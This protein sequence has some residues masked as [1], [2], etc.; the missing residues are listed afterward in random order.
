M[1]EVLVE[2][3]EPVR[4]TDGLRYIARAC[5]NET[6]TGLWQGWIE[7]VPTTGGGV[8]RSSRETT[9][10]NRQDAMYWATGLTNVYLEGALDRARKPIERAPAEPASTPAYSGPAPEVAPPPAAAEAVLNPFSVFR[11]GE[12]ALRSQL[13]A[14]AQWHLVNIVRAFELSDLSAASLGRMTAAELAELIVA[15]VRARPETPALR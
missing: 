2:F 4:D 12:A 15:E 11:K 8:L 1:A 6:A 13:G 10:P 14:L 5:A 9:Q 7:F 3:S